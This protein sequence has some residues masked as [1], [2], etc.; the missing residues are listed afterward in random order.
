M[1]QDLSWKNLSRGR[2][3]GK[4]TIISFD[5]TVGQASPVDM[6]SVS[7]PSDVDTMQLAICLST[8][9]F[10]PR[11]AGGYPPNIDPQNLSG[12]IDNDDALQAGIATI[13]GNVSAILEWGSG[14]VGQKAI[15]DF[16]NGTC[17]KISASYVR[18]RGVI[19]TVDESLSA[20][21]Y[22]L[23]AFISPGSPKD[24][25]A[26]RTINL[27]Q[28]DK[29]QESDPYSVPSFARRVFLAG[30]SAAPA[31][32]P[33]AGVIRFWRDAACTTGFV[34]EYAFTNASFAYVPIPAGAYYFTMINT[35]DNFTHVSAVFDLAI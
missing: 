32:P 21:A 6:L 20:M 24:I 11:P 4:K 23:S 30:I 28:W 33:F 18:L 9:R 10:I 15:L 19:E 13:W 16:C 5:N 3:I 12:S 2:G 29:D 22:E 27:G 31:S 14:G 25:A 35:V 34:A 8:P 1:S 26:Q 17:V 7:S